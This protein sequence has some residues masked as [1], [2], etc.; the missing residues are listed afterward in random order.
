MKLNIACPATG[1]QKTIEIEDE[2]QLR[3]FYD[4]RM[5]QEVEGDV[6]GDEW[7]GYI[8][9]ITG[10]NDKQGFPMVQGVLIN[11]RTRLLCKKGSKYYRPRK[12]GERKRK[13]I[14]GCIVSHDL[15]VLNLAIL[16][17]GDADVEGLTDEKSAKP[18]R[19]GP[20]RANNIR[21]LFNLSK[22][23]DPRS[24]IVRRPIE[25]EGK[26]SYS[27]APKIQRLITPDR[28]QR[29]LKWKAERRH[30]WEKSRA[31][32]KEY[33]ALVAQRLK[34]ERER[35]QSY[36]EKRRSL[37]R[38]MSEKKAKAKAGAA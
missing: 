27:K 25:R 8:F 17:K 32:A 18:R 22:E 12:V 5:S 35:R 34:E 4:K 9:K 1:C 36:K 20:K 33:N 19:L 38:K 21:K 14:R 29:K 7:K 16:K 31:A 37:S 28:I 23:D 26:K 11:N 30:R 13:S 6:L 10:G 15:S 2:K 3:A 24:V